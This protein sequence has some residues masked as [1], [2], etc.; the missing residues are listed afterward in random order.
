MNDTYPSGTCNLKLPLLYTQGKTAVKGENSKV[1]EHTAF[2]V[3]AL[4]N[5]W[6][7]SR[8]YRTASWTLPPDSIPASMVPTKKEFLL[9]TVTVCCGLF[10]A[11]RW[12][13]FLDSQSL[14]SARLFKI[15]FLSHREL[16]R[17]MF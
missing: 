2:W 16:K 1:G 6:T 14:A 7:L 12:I 8:M 9:L 15:T 13:K 4:D 5:L 17:V 10:L 11:D 3:H